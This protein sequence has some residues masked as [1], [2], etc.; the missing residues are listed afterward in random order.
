VEIDVVVVRVVEWSKGGGGRMKWRVR[1]CCR[2][3]WSI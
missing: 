2:I 3:K 1:G